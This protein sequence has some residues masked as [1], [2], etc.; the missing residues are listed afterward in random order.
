MIQESKTLE[1]RRLAKGLKIWLDI[2]FYLGLVAGFIVL[3]LG[4]IASLT[5]HE[6][7]E[8]TV[9][10]VSTWSRSCRRERSTLANHGG[11]QGRSSGSP[12]PGFRSQF[13]VLDVS[14]LSFSEPGSTD[15]S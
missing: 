9:P 11:C 14:A 5:G 2:I 8:I 4:P 15:S 13:G 1:R 7:Y 10:V 12:P 6:V 3:V